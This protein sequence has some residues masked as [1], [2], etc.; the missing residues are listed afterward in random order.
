M[1]ALPLLTLTCALCGL[2]GAQGFEF[3]ALD[4]P[5]RVWSGAGTAIRD[6]R[7]LVIQDPASW[8]ELWREHDP[9]ARAPEVDFTRAMVLAVFQPEWAA[10]AAFR[11]DR[12]LPG[13]L[14][15]DASSL[16][17]FLTTHKAAENRPNRFAMRQ[18]E[19]SRY[20][21]RFYAQ[22]SAKR[23]SKAKLVARVDT[24]RGPEPAASLIAAARALM[25]EHRAAGAARKQAILTQLAAMGE[26]LRPFWNRL[27]V[28]GGKGLWFAKR[29][30]DKMLADEVAAQG[31]PVQFREV[32]VAK[33][34][35]A[36]AAKVEFKGT[37]WWIQQQ[38][39]RI[40]ARWYLELH[41]TFR[42]YSDLETAR[43]P[44]IRARVA[45]NAADGKVIHC[46]VSRGE[47]DVDRAIQQGSPGVVPVKKKQGQR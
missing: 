26:A 23:A 19:R 45:L 2:A 9:A 17:V 12:V 4:Q 39:R 30:L 41:G 47:L 11:I 25:A 36:V 24:T 18:V 40:G 31:K 28:G 34:L 20:D 44:G 27:K 13:K 38:C 7:Y 6:T 22:G 15:S 32:A 14:A 3:P 37:P 16:N 46:E 35:A 21:L 43:Q 5:P 8:R 42:I 29:V 1:Q 10:G 33:A